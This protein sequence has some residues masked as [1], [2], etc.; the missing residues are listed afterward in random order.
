MHVEDSIPSLRLFQRHNDGPKDESDDECF[1][2]EDATKDRDN[3]SP[4]VRALMHKYTQLSKKID[5]FLISLQNR[6]TRY[7]V[8]DTF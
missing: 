7:I 5:R 4:A 2:P 6:Q 1:L 3:V 8:L